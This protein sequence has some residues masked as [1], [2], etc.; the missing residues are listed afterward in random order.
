M[1]FWH[2]IHEVIG[3][4]MDDFHAAMR[5][6]W[7][8]L[9][10]GEGDARLVWFWDHGHGTGPSYHAL[11]VVAVRDWTAW[12]RLVDWLVH[13]ARARAWSHDVAAL[14]RRVT[15]KL[16]LPVSWS[17][18]QEID[19][20]AD[21]PAGPTPSL[22]LHDTGW[23]FAGRLDDYVDALGTVYYPQT[24]RSGMIAIEACFRTC[25]GTGL[26]DEVLLLQRILDWEAFA[27]LL[28]EGE[29][30]HQRGGWMEEGLKYRDRWESR[31]LRAAPWSPWR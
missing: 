9:V 1:L 8:P 3:G 13:D 29:S 27:R 6:T 18:L 11:S 26:G 20:R 10:E 22:Y 24:R 30:R 4:R 14:R 21:P 23:P 19:L 15:G 7:R 5:E 16:L 12:G 2:E 28:A 31:L 17:P 25:P